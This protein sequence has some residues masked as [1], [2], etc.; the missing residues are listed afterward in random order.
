MKWTKKEIEILQTYY[1]EHSA[2]ECIRKFNLTCTVKALQKKA[3]ELGINKNYGWT[4]EEIEILKK[5]MA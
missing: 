5:T 3:R 4:E 2:E 1:L